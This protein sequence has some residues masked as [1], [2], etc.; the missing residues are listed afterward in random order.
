MDFDADKGT[1]YNPAAFKPPASPGYIIV[2]LDNGTPQ[3]QVTVNTKIPVFMDMDLGASGIST[4]FTKS[5]L[6]ANPGIVEGGFRGNGAMIGTLAQ[7]GLG[8]FQFF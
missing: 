1:F 3:V 4:I 7:I 6:Q 2:G 5:F 8:P